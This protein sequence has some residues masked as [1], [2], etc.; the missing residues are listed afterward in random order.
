MT[1]RWRTSLSAIVAGALAISAPTGRISAQTTSPLSLLNQVST[2][3]SGGTPIGSVQLTGRVGRNAGSATDTG[4]LTLTANAD[5]ST[6]M[7]VSLSGG[8]RTESQT[9]IGPTRSCLWSG[10][11]GV[12]HDSSGPNCWPLLLCWNAI[13]PICTPGAEPIGA[14]A[15]QTGIRGRRSCGGKADTYQRRQREARKCIQK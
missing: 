1:I 14:A 11:D 7:Q 3:F 9:S 6:Q 5:G 2:S 10:S 12:I 8:V 4:T 15:S 13:K